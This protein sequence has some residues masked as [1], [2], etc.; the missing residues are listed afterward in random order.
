MVTYYIAQLGL[1]LSVVGCEVKSKKYEEK[2][3][4]FKNDSA[5]K[6]HQTGVDRRGIRS[7]I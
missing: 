1:A 5:A 3:D 2:S 6:I 7:V 4:A